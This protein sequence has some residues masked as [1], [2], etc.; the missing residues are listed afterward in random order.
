MSL[1]HVI[2]SWLPAWVQAAILGLIALVA[3]IVILKIV[4]LVLDAIPF[5]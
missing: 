3:I 2:F 1:W 5:L 4:A